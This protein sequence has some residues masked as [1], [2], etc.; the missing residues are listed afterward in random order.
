M[1]IAERAVVRDGARR[2][3]VMEIAVVDHIRTAAVPVHRTAS[4]NLD[5]SRAA[6]LRVDGHRKAAAIDRHRTAGDW[7][8]GQGKMDEPPTGGLG[9]SASV[10]SPGELQITIRQVSV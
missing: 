1:S 5:E 10:H 7:S 3:V 2:V 4:A 6:A 8:P 9:G